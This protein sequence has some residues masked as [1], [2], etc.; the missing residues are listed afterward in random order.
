V[1]FAQTNLYHY[2]LQEAKVQGLWANNDKSYR[3][4]EYH[5]LRTDLTIQARQ[6]PEI[7]EALEIPF[8]DAY[9]LKL[10]TSGN[11]HDLQVFAQSNQIT[12]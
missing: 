11:Y 10:G 6:H 3:R 2:H 8:D 5:T 12:L 1:H 4:D 9:F 7:L